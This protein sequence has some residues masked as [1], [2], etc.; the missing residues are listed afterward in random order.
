MEAPFIVPH[1]DFFIKVGYVPY[2][3]DVAT[4]K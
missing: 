1:L 2:G 4:S 3:V